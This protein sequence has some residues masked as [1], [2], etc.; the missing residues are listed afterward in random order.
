MNYYYDILVNLQDE[1]YEFYEWE[2]TDPILA[3]KK[4]PLFK[5][6]HQVIIDFLT[7]DITLNEDFIINILDKTT[8]KNNKEKLNAFLISDTKTSLFLETNDEGKI[9]F[10]SKLLVEDENNVN[11]VVSVLKPTTIKYQKGAKIIK[12]NLLRRTRKEK[13]LISAEL[14]SL[15]K[16]QNVDKCNYLYYELFHQAPDSYEQALLKMQEF[17]KNNNSQ[18][19]HHLAHLIDITYQEKL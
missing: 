5:V 8:S 12:N 14:N 11:E 15:K 2:K 17:L 13:N 19:I 9:I 16:E 6:D 10:K 1:F 3:I 4:T 7:R 18:L